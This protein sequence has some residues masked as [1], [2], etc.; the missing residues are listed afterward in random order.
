MG[1]VV[2]PEGDDGLACRDLETRTRVVLLLLLFLLLLWAVDR[3]RMRVV[4]GQRIMGLDA[5]RW[6]GALVEALLTC[7]SVTSLLPLDGEREL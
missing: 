4:L 3:V 1:A 5:H 2:L 7:L 6:L